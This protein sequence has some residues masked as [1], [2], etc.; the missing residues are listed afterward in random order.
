MK[1]NHL[2]EPEDRP[3]IMQVDIPQLIVSIPI[4]YIAKIDNDEIKSNLIST[5]NRDIKSLCSGNI[6]KTNKCRVNKTTTKHTNTAL[7]APN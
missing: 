7:Y 4:K 5:F 6:L 2:N 1:A 3:E